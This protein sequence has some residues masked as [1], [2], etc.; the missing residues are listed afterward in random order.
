MTFG[1]IIDQAR[2]GTL[3]KIKELKSA[4]EA[5]GFSVTLEPAP[6]SHDG[7][8]ACAS[9]GMRVPLRYDLAFRGP[10][11]GFKTEYAESVTVRWGSPIS[12]SWSDGL[13]IE[14]HTICWDYLSFCVSMGGSPFDPQAIKTWFLKWFDTED[15]HSPDED[16][17]LR[18]VHF[19]SDPESDDGCTAF[20]VD[21]G[22]ADV[23]A[24]EDIFDVLDRLGAKRCVIGQ[25]EEP[26]QPPEPT[27]GLAPGRG[28]S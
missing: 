24:L 17:F 21:F 9:D 28:S 6:R 23:A 8:L 16:G 1:Q 25:E 2:A 15:S 13:K 18:V 11:T 10:N 14:A 26:N 20:V 12:F 4:K 7:A 19:I 22:S 27:S 3:R 5:E